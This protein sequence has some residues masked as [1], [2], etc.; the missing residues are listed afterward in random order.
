MA[1]FQLPTTGKRDRGRTWLRL[2]ACRRSISFVHSLNA[3]SPSFL[4]I[5]CEL[6]CIPSQCHF[7]KTVLRCMGMCSE[8]L[9]RIGKATQ[10]QSTI[11]FA[12]YKEDIEFTSTAAHMINY[13]QQPNSYPLPDIL[14]V[15]EPLL[16]AV[17][18]HLDIV[19]SHCLLQAFHRYV[20]G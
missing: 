16:C 3:Y 13:E 2:A 7:V 1:A 5:T 17:H 15:N 12:M 9:G 18:H 19:R 4:H 20:S 14:D 6:K 11:P 8:A 10:V